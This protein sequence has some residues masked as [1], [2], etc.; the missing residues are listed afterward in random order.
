[1]ERIELE[2]VTRGGSFVDKIT[3]SPERAS[4]ALADYL[5]RERIDTA[6]WDNYRIRVP[7]GLGYEYV[8]AA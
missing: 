1:M 4:V 5:E 6:R 7:R 8:S 3:T 2:I